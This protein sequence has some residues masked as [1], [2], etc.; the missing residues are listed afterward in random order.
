[1]SS[2]RMVER[3]LDSYDIFC[4]VG[5]VLSGA[6]VAEKT[7]LQEEHRLAEK[8]DC[9]GGLSKISTGM[10]IR[11]NLDDDLP[12]LSTDAPLLQF[13]NHE[14]TRAHLSLLTFTSRG[15]SK[16]SRRTNAGETTSK[17][18][19]LRRR[20]RCQVMGKDN[21][22]VGNSNPSNN[23]Y[24]K[25]WRNRICNGPYLFKMCRAVRAP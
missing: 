6:F 2:C 10:R 23:G 13:R 7:W 16:R 20:Y 1:M 4:I 12:P 3:G 8:S 17:D 19:R 18:S 5:A 25:A 9:I 21:V 24:I 11:A 22:R 15:T 14:S